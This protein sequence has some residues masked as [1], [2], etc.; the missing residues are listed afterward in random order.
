M[1]CRY[2][3]TVLVLVLAVSCVGLVSAEN[4][5]IDQGVLKDLPLQSATNLS[6]NIA[7][8]LH[9]FSFDKENE[10]WSAYN[11]GER[12]GIIA[13]ADRS[14]LLTHSHGSFG[15][16]L[17]GLGRNDE[18]ILLDTGTIGA[19]G[20]RL[21]IARPG[22][23]E[24]YINKDEGIEQGMTII[25]RP[26][27]TGKLV[28]LYDLSGTLVPVP[29]GQTLVLSDQSGPVLRYSGLKA[30]DATGRELPA[31][32]NFSRTRLSWE[33]DDRDAMYPLTIDPTITEDKI[34]SAWDKAAQD[35]FGWSVAVS[36]DTVVV[37]AWGA[38]SGGTD[39]GQ[40]YVFSRNQGGT[41]TWG[42]VMTLIASDQTDFDWFG[43]SVAV[44]GD[45]VVVGAPYASSGGAY[46]GQAY[47]FSRNQGGT[48]TWGQVKVLSASD[49]ADYNKFGY[50][51]AVSGDTVVVGAYYADSGGSYR[52]QAYIFSRNQ[53]GTNFWGQVKVLSASDKADFNYFG[54]SVAVSG[55]TVVVGATNSYSWGVYG[56]QAYVFSR[57]Q[58]GTNTWGQ[59]KI[60][61]ASD[62][63]EG[64]Y[65]G[66]SVAVSEDTGV[67]G[68]YGAYSG[69]VDGGLAYVFLQLAPTVS[70]IGVFRN[71]T[72]LFYVDY[73]GNGAWNGASIDR[74]YTFGI[75]GDLPVTGDWNLDGRTEIG[76]FRNSTHLFY[77]DYNGN[78]AWNGAAIDKSY[79]FGITGDIPVAGD[80]NSDGK[81][82][83][84]VFRN[85]THL[86][87]LD[88]DGNGV[89]N[90][91][92]TDK[93]Y[94]FGI[95]GDIPI[96]GD[97]NADGR[98][99]IG[100]FRNST[101]L[102]YVDYNGNGAWN[103][104]VTDK[105]FNFGITG[106]IPVTG[107]WNANGT[108]EIGVFRPSTHLFYVD[109]NG[110]GVWNGAVTD[111]SY[112]FGITGDKPLSG[113]W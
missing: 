28:V 19:D 20:R 91:A 93:S 35:Y 79:N 83:I 89:W 54:W 99:E 5:G 24:W 12:T 78:G 56:G 85:S 84:G 94:N 41:N 92:V 48:N 52:G 25:T 77:L 68:A 3:L 26:E 49:Q 15:M 58:G 110:N 63:E 37:G 75:S 22:S 30:V 74:Q 112:N 45:T 69:G 73:N 96:T 102:F 108:T 100:V 95:S 34:L 14:V 61:S 38:N 2:Y 8:V 88:Y 81:T 66:Y 98:T 105:S 107:D 47:V 6:A 71:S 113:K 70:N 10:T 17:A 104:A 106:D 1:K 31:V 64:N 109:Y 23:T 29:D 33:I 21:K 13:M 72:H 101:H 7:A 76:V 18:I 53:G 111:K 82:E 51:V 36:G 65:F 40:A 55:N 87:Y 39:R 67:V 59:V 103:G 11:Y 16:H 44:S 62:K 42:L 80:W 27:G 32:L 9:A 57:N 46:G 97:W 60:L 86:F 50:S 43:Y 4:I 90:G